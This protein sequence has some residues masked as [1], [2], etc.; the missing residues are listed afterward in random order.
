M[1][2]FPALAAKGQWVPLEEGEEL[3]PG[4][5]YKVEYVFTARPP[6]GEAFIQNAIQSYLSDYFYKAAE[7]FWWRIVPASL[8]HEV[9]LTGEHTYTVWLKFQLMGYPT[10]MEP[11]PAALPVITAGMILKWFL[12]AVVGALGYIAITTVS[13]TTYKWEE[14]IEV[15]AEAAKKSIRYLI[16]AL[17]IGFVLY[18]FTTWGLKARKVA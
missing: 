6:V 12:A 11:P 2:Y 17:A 7:D 9:T 5:W 13:T 3:Q 14:V 10:T 4:I 16:P 15:A 1:V 8:S 18:T